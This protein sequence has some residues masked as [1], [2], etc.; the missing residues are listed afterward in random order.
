MTLGEWF[1]SPKVKEAVPLRQLK[2]NLLSNIQSLDISL[3]TAL[4]EH[5]R[6]TSRHKKAFARNVSL[7]LHEV[8][9]KYNFWKQFFGSSKELSKKVLAFIK[10]AQELADLYNDNEDNA[11][12]YKF[13]LMS[14]FF[15]MEINRQNR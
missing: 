15:L 12:M 11:F 13:F 10:A 8:L 7:E 6:F 1:V 4:G 5:K 3:P 14:P 9:P 2:N